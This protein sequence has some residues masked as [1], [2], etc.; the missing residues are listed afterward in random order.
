MA[1]CGCAGGQCGCLVQGVGSISITGTGT[2]QDPY[3]VSLDGLDISDTVAVDDGTN[4][5]L[6]LGG[7][8]TALDPYVISASLSVGATVTVTPTTGGTTTIDSGTRLEYMDH[9]STIATQ[10]IVLPTTSTAMEKEIKILA[11]SEITTLT[12]SGDVGVTVVGM[13]TTLAANG[14]FRVQLIGT[15]WHRIG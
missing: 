14:Y 1:K 12:V 6:T 11:A 4:I 13:P 8:G 2:Q 5:A 3:V 10:T 7:S 15:V 9:G